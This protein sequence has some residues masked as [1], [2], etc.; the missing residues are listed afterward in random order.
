MTLASTPAQANGLEM[1]GP[2]TSIDCLPSSAKAVF[3]LLRDG[4]ER[5]LNEIIGRV[6]FSPRTIRNAL[7]K[8]RQSGLIVAKFNFRDARKP[9]YQLKTG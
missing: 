2:V 3:A 5:T 4:K 6:A 9:L 7:N 8:L 1:R